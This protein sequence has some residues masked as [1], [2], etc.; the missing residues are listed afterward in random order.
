MPRAR[1]PIVAIMD[2]FETADLVEV[3]QALKVIKRT[4]E[5]RRVP[6]PVVKKRAARKPKSTAAPVSVDQSK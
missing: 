4:V 3:E 6:A 2:F 5:R 1:D